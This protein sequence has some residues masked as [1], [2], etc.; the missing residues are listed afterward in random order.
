MQP[1]PPRNDDDETVFE[2]RILPHSSLTRNG[3][4]WLLAILFG[5]CLLMGLRFLLIG[6]WP[7]AIFAVL[8][9]GLFLILFRMHWRAMRRSELILLSPSALTIIRHEPGGKRSEHHL[10]PTWLRVVLQE[11]AGRVPALLLA[12]RGQREEIARVL[13]ET[14]KRHLAAALEGALHRLRNP[15]FDNPQLRETC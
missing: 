10:Q 6:A 15:V 14:E 8:E 4:R 1:A 7:V 3:W 5:A 2:A 11:R 12:A 13:G 9:V